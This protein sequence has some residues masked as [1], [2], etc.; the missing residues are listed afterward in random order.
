M[1]VGSSE[2]K[3][4]KADVDPTATDSGEGTNRKRSW[5]R[6]IEVVSCLKKIGAWLHVSEV[7]IALVSSAYPSYHR[8]KYFHIQQTNTR[9]SCFSSMLFHSFGANDSITFI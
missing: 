7:H 6:L 5:V 8:V 3:K 1:G 9:A 4:K 2:L